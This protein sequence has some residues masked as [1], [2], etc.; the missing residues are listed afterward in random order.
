MIHVRFDGHD[1]S[2]RDLAI[3]AGICLGGRD[4]D[5]DLQSLVGVMERQPEE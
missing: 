1:F 4:R 5:F 2:E 3:R